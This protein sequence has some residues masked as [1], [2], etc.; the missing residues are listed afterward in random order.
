I[1]M[2]LFRLLDGI[3]RAAFRFLDTPMPR[4]GCFVNRA[5]FGQFRVFK[6]PFHIVAQRAESGGMRR[7]PAITEAGDL[8]G[9]TDP[10][11]CML[12]REV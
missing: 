10:V 12:Q 8:P 3:R 11:P 5:G 6:E 7:N 4:T 9:R 2:P 1:R